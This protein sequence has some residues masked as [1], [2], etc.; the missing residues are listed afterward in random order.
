MEQAIQPFAFGDN[1]VRTVMD[2]TGAIWF[3]ARDVCNV[4]GLD[5]NRKAVAGLDEDEKGVTISDTPGGEQTLTTISESGMY[6]L[7]FRS[8]KPAAR[9]FSKWVRAEVLPSLRRT[10]SYQMPTAAGAPIPDSLPEEALSLRPALRL[11]LWQNALQTA[12]LDGANSAA[13]MEWF[14]RLCDMM[15]GRRGRGGGASSAARQKAD[16]AA[17]IE[18][19]L[20]P[21]PDECRTGMSQIWD[22][23]CL[24]WKDNSDAPRPRKDVLAGHVMEHFPRKWRDA[25]FFLYACRVREAV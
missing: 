25:G 16:I 2:E 24:W 10:G 17:Y 22:D 14:V 5:N 4:L 21:T 9:A 3:V 1:L 20:E 23:F 13:A 6:A 15:K 18:E 7:V 11:Q 12:R 19:R 8:R